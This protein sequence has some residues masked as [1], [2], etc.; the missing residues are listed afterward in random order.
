MTLSEIVDQLES[1]GYTCEAG[2]L[3]HNVAFIELKRIASEQE[4]RDGKQ[5]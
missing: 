5:S 1:C 4:E 2:P 3:S